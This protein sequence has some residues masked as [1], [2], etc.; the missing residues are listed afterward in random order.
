MYFLFK[1][2]LFRD[3]FKWIVSVNSQLIT[4]FQHIH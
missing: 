4:I 3:L 1:D 2:I